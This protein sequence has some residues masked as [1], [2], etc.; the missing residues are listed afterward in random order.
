MGLSDLFR[1]DEMKKQCQELSELKQ[2]YQELLE[3]CEKIKG[4]KKHLL[5]EVL[6]LSRETGPL[7]MSAITL[8]RSN[9]DMSADIDSL[10]EFV[11]SLANRNRELESAFTDEHGEVIEIKKLLYELRAE[12][13]RL[14]EEIAREKE[15][16]ENMRTQRERIQRDVIELKETK[17]LQDFGLYEPMYEFAYSSQYQERLCACRE[18]Q[19]HMVK[20]GEAAVCSTSWQVNGS[21]AAGK[22]M[23]SD[24]IKSALLAFNTECE[25]AIS[26][27]KFNNYESMKK[28]IEQIFKKIN[29]MN[30]TNDIKISDDF[31][32]LKFNELALAYEYSRK[33]QEEKER[34]REQREIERENLKVQREIEAERKRIEKEKIHYQN[35][36]ARL[37]EQMEQEKSEARKQFIREKIDAARGELAEL[38]KA[39]KDVDYRAANERAGY[40]YVISNIGAFGE[41]V[42]KIGMTRRLEPKDRIDELGGASVPFRFDIHAMIFSDDAPKLETALHNAFADRR[43]NMVNGRKEF[44]RVPLEEI[45]RVVTENYDRTVDF[46][47]LADAEQY[48]ESLKMK[49]E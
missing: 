49:G 3:S 13:D 18:E 4:E 25:N 24:N 19:K 45:E 12:K 20:A 48:R 9:S 39:L 10:K 17:L 46:K 30:S 16:A 7:K 29:R 37:R 44:F 38:D 28:R 35:V 47:Y 23:T 2:K 21:L 6:Q 8:K 42:Y 36:M 32:T 1:V 41:G 15:V 14:E 11:G 5:S 43:V 31:L 34:A 27:V 22:K 40:V 26:K 33:K